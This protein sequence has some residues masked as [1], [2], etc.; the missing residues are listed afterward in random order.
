MKADRTALELAASAHFA[1]FLEH[2]LA[3]DRLVVAQQ[4]DPQG[5]FVV[6]STHMLH[7]ISD[8]ATISDKKKDLVP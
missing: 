1:D 3:I 7:G 5:Q 2:P 8:R 6:T 4:T